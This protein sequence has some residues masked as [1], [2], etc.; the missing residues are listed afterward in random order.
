MQCTLHTLNICNI[1]LL[2][3]L[4]RKKSLKEIPVVEYLKV[5]LQS[6]VLKGYKQK[7]NSIC[8]RSRFGKLL[9]AEGWTKETDYHFDLSSAARVKYATFAF[10]SNIVCRKETKESVKLRYRYGQSIHTSRRILRFCIVS[11]QTNSFFHINLNFL[12]LSNKWTQP[13]LWWR[14]FSHFSY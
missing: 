14:D 6:L 2:I 5:L 3:C 1:Y 7:Y 4:Y 8:T 11:P 12:N 13:Y 9:K 10:W